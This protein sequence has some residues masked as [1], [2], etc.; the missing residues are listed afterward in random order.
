MENVKTLYEH[1][2]DKQLQKLINSF[3][4]RVFKSPI[5]G[6]LF[7]ETNADAI[8]DKQYRF[9]TQLLGGP[10][11]YSEKYGHPRMRMRHMPHAITPEAK[12]EWLK[13]MK[14]AIHDLDISD[15][16]K[17]ALYLEQSQFL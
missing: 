14:D 7:N 10:S 1:L 5:I 8:K 2:G 3:Y 15:E 13:L 9:L 11:R 16:L 12:E 17:N 4:A 6:P